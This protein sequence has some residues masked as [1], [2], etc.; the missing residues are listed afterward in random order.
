MSKNKQ[1]WIPLSIWETFKRGTANGATQ[2]EIEAKN[3]IMECVSSGVSPEV[4]QVGDKIV[5]RGHANKYK[6][7]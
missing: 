1:R 2:E 6:K 3:K 4:F 5:V 7:F